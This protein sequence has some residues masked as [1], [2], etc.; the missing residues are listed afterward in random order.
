MKSANKLL[1]TGILMS[2]VAIPILAGAVYSILKLK[3]NIAGSA[4]GG[5]F[6]LLFLLGGAMMIV[7]SIRRSRRFSELKKNG[8]RYVGR[9]FAHRKEI[10]ND[11]SLLVRYFDECGD[12]R[13][14]AI[15]TDQEKKEDYPIAT[16]VVFLKK[17]DDAALLEKCSTHFSEEEHDRLTAWR[18]GGAIKPR[19]PSKYNE[20]DITDIIAP[21]DATV[22]KLV[23]EIVA[24]PTGVFRSGRYHLE[25]RGMEEEFED[26]IRWLGMVEILLE[27]GYVCELD[28]KET[29][30]VVISSV[31]TL[32]GMERLGLTLNESALEAQKY[33][34]DWCRFID[35]QWE[36][37]DCCLGCIDI[38]SDSYVLFPCKH[39]ELKRLSVIA[40]DM[41][42][43]I[44]RG[45]DS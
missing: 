27:Q 25:E 15:T 4:I 29:P 24:D 1:I 7:E 3:E 26:E 18:V 43:V 11:I 30:D 37:M 35:R 19:T 44:A 39:T 23:E 10:T 16:D 40:A 14:I 17:D 33:V 32:K 8:T 21:G 12:V 36:D 28:Y 45:R 42:R 41:D 5:F 34:A 9:V 20:T 13:Q 31:T 22:Q 38:E 2:V 6:A